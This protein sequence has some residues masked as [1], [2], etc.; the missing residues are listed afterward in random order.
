MSYI[1]TKYQSNYHNWFRL[2]YK[3]DACIYV[4]RLMRLLQVT[5][6][7]LAVTRLTTRVRYMGDNAILQSIFM[8]SLS[9]AGICGL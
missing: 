9:N 1:D 6:S 2:S 5:A 3:T 4:S 7:Q 8:L